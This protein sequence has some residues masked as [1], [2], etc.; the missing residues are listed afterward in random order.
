MNEPR[1][2]VICVESFNQAKHK[3]ICCA[4]CQFE[5]CRSCCETYL[6]N[7]TVEKCMSA[8]C[9][10]TWT[11][12][13][14]TDNFV[15][16][17]VT[18][19]LKKHKEDVLF[20]KERALLPATQELVEEQ[21]R[22]ENLAELVKEEVA[23]ILAIRIEYAEKRRVINQKSS[24]FRNNKIARKTFI[25]ACPEEN[26]LGFLSSQWKCGLC[27]KWAC[28][29]CHVVLG[30]HRDCGHKCNPDDVATAKLLA[31]DTKPCPKCSTSIF[32]IDGCD[33]MFCTQCH[34]AFGWKTG[35]IEYNIHNPHYFEWLR[36]NRNE[37]PERNPLDIVCGQEIDFNF[38]VHMNDMLNK[39]KPL[40]DTVTKVMNLCRQII[41][42]RAVELPKFFVDDVTDNQSLRIQYM[43]NKLNEQEFKS[44]L[45][46]SQ[47]NHDIKREIRDV[48]IMFLN[49]VTDIIYR[50]YEQLKISKTSVQVNN[51]RFVMNDVNPLI[52]YV[53]ECFDNISENFKSAKYIIKI[54]HYFDDMSIDKISLAQQKKMNT[55][56]L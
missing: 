48:L 44:K 30:L 16:S 40:I 20:E 50:Y 49:V 3:P 36:K 38:T 35:N 56:D 14:I 53:Q 12:K 24:D 55:V 43:R 6:L 9:G 41:H 31:S 10:K 11:R 51:C 28:P 29:E 15:N 1:T 21:L 54:D 26:C 45:F 8:S 19:P 17:F 5:A 27:S 42:I 33:Q 4:Y 46:T 25:R 34:T 2:C 18:G 47:K 37:N 39:K 23:K 13:F 7:E 52:L 22:K 32:K